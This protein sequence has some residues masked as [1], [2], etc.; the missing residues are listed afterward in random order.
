MWVSQLAC[1]LLNRNKR[2]DITVRS[3]CVL[4]QGRIM[5]K[6]S[7]GRVSRLANGWTWS[8]RELRKTWGR[9]GPLVLVIG[10]T[11]KSPHNFPTRILLHSSGQIVDLGTVGPY[12]TM[13]ITK[14]VSFGAS[15][16]VEVKIT[17]VRESDNAVQDFSFSDISESLTRH[18]AE[19][20]ESEV[21]AEGESETIV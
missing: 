4:A 16:S 3:I 13:P 17:L 15:H 2:A 12:A 1:Q 9:N 19:D 8:Y 10:L 11:I 21:E 6:Y 5:K 7:L 20:G 14:A 18:V